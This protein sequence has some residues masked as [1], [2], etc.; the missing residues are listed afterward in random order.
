VTGGNN[1]DDVQTAQRVGTFKTLVKAVQAAGLMD[2]LS[3]SGPFTLFAPTDD[4]FGRLAEGTLDG[5]MKDIPQ[6]RSVLNCH[7]VYGKHMAA[8]IEAMKSV[9]NLQGESLAI[10][11][12][13]GV[14][15]RGAELIQTDIVAD[16]GVIHVIDGVLTPGQT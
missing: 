14:R 1:G 11:I 6:L 4:A 9:K 12:T 5:W 16:N 15:I 8:D 13:R 10:D 7:L 3:G 2:T